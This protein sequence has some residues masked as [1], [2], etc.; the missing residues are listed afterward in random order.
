MFGRLKPLG[1]G[2]GAGARRQVGGLDLRDDLPEMAM[3]L[4][5]PVD[6]HVDLERPERAPLDF[7]PLERNPGQ[8]EAGR[9]PGQRVERQAGVDE[10]GARRAGT[11][12]R[13]VP[14]RGR[15]ARGRKVHEEPQVRAEQAHFRRDCVDPWGTGIL[16]AMDGVSEAGDPRPRR[17]SGRNDLV[18]HVAQHRVVRI[19]TYV[20]RGE[21]VR[22]ELRGV[23]GR[24]E[25]HAAGTEEPG[26]D[27]ALHGLRR[28]GVGEPRR[29]RAR[30]ET[31]VGEGDEYRV[32]EQTLRRVG[33]TSGDEK[34]RELGERQVTHDLARKIATGDRDAVCAR[35]SDPGAQP[36]RRVGG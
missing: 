20:V 1:Q 14:P 30:R 25:E 17:A 12:D 27:R 3:G 18:G 15:F 6:P 23:A 10:R 29:Q 4:R 36:L 19:G 13:K 21:R 34:V 28:T 9:Q 22:E 24:A 16:L 32:D 26:C 7:A 2:A 5:R 35:R 8:A 31:V 33:L 11:V